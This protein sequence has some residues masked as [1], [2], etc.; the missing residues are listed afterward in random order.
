MFVGN[1]DT[2]YILDKSEQNAAQIN[3]HPAMGAVYD[4]AS[5]TATTIQVVSNPF[6]ASGMHMPNGS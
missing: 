5:R 1:E 4:I 3:G 6:C 2:V